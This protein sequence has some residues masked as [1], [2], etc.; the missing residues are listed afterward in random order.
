MFGNWNRCI[1]LA[2]CQHMTILND[3]DMFNKGVFSVPEIY[4]YNSLI[5]FDRLELNQ[6]KERTSF[7]SKNLRFIKN[8]PMTYRGIKASD[9]IIGNPFT[10]SLGI[11]FKKNKALEIGGFNEE[12]YPSSDYHFFLRYIIKYGGEYSH[13]KFFIYNWEDNVS[14][15]PETLEGFTNVSLLIRRELLN[16]LDLGKFNFKIYHYFFYFIT[17]IHRKRKKIKLKNLSYYIIF[18]I[19]SLYC[20]YFYKNLNK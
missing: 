15:K 5:A 11:F 10:S 3:D 6:G 16:H 8:L 13:R 14:L 12:Y 7:I 17:F 4:S 20:R 9:F 1:Q 18:Y 2:A 19:L